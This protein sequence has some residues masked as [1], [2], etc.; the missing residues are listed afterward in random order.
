MGIGGQPTTFRQFAT[1]VF[2]LLHGET[3]K[4]EGSRIDS[5]RSMALDVNDVSFEFLRAG[6]EEVVIAHFVKRG[7]RGKRRNVTANACRML[8]GS[9]DHRHCVP[10]D[11]T[12]YP[13]FDRQVARILG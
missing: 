11:Q 8:V 13:A 2:H 10:A 7:R 3:S 5:R 6:A 12:L 9:K 4:K 1:E